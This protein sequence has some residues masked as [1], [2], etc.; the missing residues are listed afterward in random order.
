MLRRLALRVAPMALASVLVIAV[1]ADPAR[2]EG[3]V[4]SVATVPTEVDP[5][6]PAGVE[7]ALGQ[8][9]ATALSLRVLDE[10]HQPAPGVE[11][12]LTVI[13]SEFNGATG[14]V[15]S[16]TVTT[17]A[18]GKAS[19]NVT[20]G[21]T[22]GFWSVKASVGTPDTA[23]FGVINRPPGFRVGEHLAS[24]SGH[25]Q[26]GAPVAVDDYLDG[27]GYLV[28][29]VCAVD[30]AP[31]RAVAQDEDDAEDQL[32]EEGIP[33]RVV[34]VLSQ[35]LS[36]RATTAVDASNWRTNVARTD[37]PVLHSNG[38]RTG[39]LYRAALFA[40]GAGGGFPTYLFVAPDGT[41][42]GRTSLALTSDQIAR[43][44]RIHADGVDDTPQA[45]VSVTIDGATS[46]GLA[47]PTLAGPFGSLTYDAAIHAQEI[48]DLVL[49]SEEAL[50]SA[51]PVAL[52]VTP[53]RSDPE[54]RYFPEG[55]A[56][57]LVKIGDGNPGSVWWG[58]SLGTA[59]MTLDTYH[60]DVDLST[61]REQVAEALAGEGLTQ[62]EIDAYVAS[63]DTVKLTFAAE[64]GT[65]P[66]CDGQP[67]TITGRGRIDG[68]SG[69]DVIVGSAGDDEIKGAG[70]NDVI[71][72]LGGDDLIYDGA[73][74]DTVLGSRGNDAFVQGASADPGDVLDGGNG[75]DNLSYAARPV[76]V[77]VT[78]DA[79]ADDGAP[80][81]GDKVT[82]TVEEVTGTNADDTINGNAGNNR[83]VGRG[84]NDTLNGGGGNDALRGDAGV[85][86]LNGGPGNDTVDG[87]PGDD[88]LRGGA[89]N[90]N[91]LGGADNDTI[92]EEPTTSGA[93]AVN[94]NAGHDTIRYSSRTTSVAI[95]LNGDPTSGAP[96]EFD[97]IVG[98]EEAFGGSADDQLVGGPYAEIFWGMAGAD[99]INGGGGAD[100]ITGG[101]GADMLFGSNGTDHLDSRDGVKGNDTINGGT[102][103]DTAVFDPGD[104]LI[105][106]P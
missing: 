6:G 7:A 8:P 29:N 49:E 24:I 14:T 74:A 95:R 30:C 106:V 82:A 42:F 56:H 73:G 92:T 13:P 28:L 67:A 97:R 89:D 17:N 25:D 31:C 10:A 19:F 71:C 18:A 32:A 3:P 81:E 93:D 20:A 57:V 79:L 50:T 63:L 35:D 80:G 102:A 34:R 39:S 104:I 66:S 46:S 40:V 23:F 36:G 1:P 96:G 78:L 69:A 48:T 62:P 99:T 65:P 91:V 41:I 64:I 54:P 38:S 15:S 33:A 53:A 9:I 37:D 47:D 26:T 51:E 44:I 75:Q 77:T 105:S 88:A 55:S 16:P 85:D 43:K 94:G 98:V 100:Q 58:V 103:T 101:T 12:S 60:L 22:P 27:S 61:A 2:A 72:G 4:V 76:G 68:T 59:T 87:G 21:S 83:F 70:G 86:S 90:D 45:Q 52:E 5:I 84:G 11:V